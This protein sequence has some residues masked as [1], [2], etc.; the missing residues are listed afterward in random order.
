MIK[1]HED[2]ND[3]VARKQLIMN[4]CMVNLLSVTEREIER[5][6][7]FSESLYPMFATHHSRREKMF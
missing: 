3:H 5:V 7:E 2:F 1:N 4:G 6:L